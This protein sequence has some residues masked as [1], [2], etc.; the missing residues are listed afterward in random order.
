MWRWAVFFL[1]LLKKQQHLEHKNSASQCGGPAASNSFCLLLLTVG[2]GDGFPPW[3]P[4]TGPPAS[5]VHTL[6]AV[7]S[8][9]EESQR[10]QLFHLNLQPPNLI[11]QRLQARQGQNR[12]LW[13]EEEGG[14]FPSLPLSPQSSSLSRTRLGVLRAAKDREQ[15]DFMQLQ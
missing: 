15:N 11:I 3:H 7:G 12:H 1:F 8:V 10:E 2:V 6:E 5:A 13:K 14:L 4:P 9:C